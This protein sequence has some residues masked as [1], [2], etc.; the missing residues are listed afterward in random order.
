VSRSE[1][2]FERLLNVG[3]GR[4][5]HPSWTNI[6]LVACGPEVRQYDLRRGLP[7]EANSFDAVYH[8]HVLEHLTQKDAVSMLHQCRQVLRPGGVMRVVVPDL[9]GIARTYL[10]TLEAAAGED[11]EMAVA[12]HHWMTLELLDQ[13]TRRRCGGEM[14]SA[15]RRIDQPN[16]QFIRQRMGGEMDEPA[17]KTRKTIAM[18]LSRSVRDV[19]KQLALAAVTLIEGTSGREVYQEGSFRQT[20]EIHRWMY[21]RVSLSRLLQQVGFEEPAVCGASESRIPGFD[22]YQLDRVNGVTRKPDSLF[23]EAIK[24]MASTETAACSRSA[25]GDAI[26]IA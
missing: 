13:M 23:I 8:S 17:V 1:E 21:D 7:Y 19:R 4:W 22:A 18:R 2:S 11:D 5:Y 25:Q 14:G 9:E 16:L 6:D 3:C 20:G 12:N 10:Q 24:P 15:M 26:G